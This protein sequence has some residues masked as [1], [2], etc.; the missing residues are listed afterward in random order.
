VGIRAS[1]IVA[2]TAVF[3]TAHASLAAGTVEHGKFESP[4]LGVFKAFAVYLPQGYSGGG[5]RFPV[6][7]LL[8]GWGV[9][10]NAWL[11]KS[12]DLPGAADE[13]RLQAIVV[14]P[15]GDR[16][17]YANSVTPVDYE[18]CLA[19]TPPKRNKNEDRKEFCVR[20][21]HYED[22]IA[23]DLVKYIDKN[24]RTLPRREARAVV[25]ESAGG[26]GAMHLAMRHKDVFS[27][28]A[29]H[30][31]ALALLYDGPKPYDASKVRLRSNFDTYPV[32]LK[33]PIEIFGTDIDRWR[34]Y[35]PSS[36]VDSLRDGELAIYFDCGEQDE[37]GFHDHA[38]LF[39][40]RLREKGIRHEFV[41][42][43]GGHDE[44]L[45]KERIKVS[46]RFIVE[47]FSSSGTYHSV[48]KM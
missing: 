38:M 33:E 43:P 2:V 45:W 19:G 5:K 31:G 22:Y 29:S 42:V 46:L 39:D 25:G 12:L 27:I 26:L 23:R 17:F 47:H 32:G 48:D 28:A 37:T 9:T 18:S 44:S 8:H 3:V 36:L 11:A 35:D 24:Y 20:F 30:S 21:P 6:I 34:S 41:S 16:S 4:S 40:S 15:D 14:M 1:T 10:E 7:Y 13:M